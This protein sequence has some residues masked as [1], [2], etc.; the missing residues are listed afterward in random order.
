MN[1]L[2]E[3]LPTFAQNM[4][5]TWAG[6]VRAR[7]RFSR[8]F[9]RMLREWQQT[10]MA[11][12]ESLLIY[13][14]NR[15]DAMVRHAQETVPRYRELKGPSKEPDARRAIQETL[16][17]IPILDKA[18]YRDHFEEFL[19]TNI[20]AGRI[21]RSQTSGTTGTALPLAYTPE[22]IAEEY[23]A[24]WR[25]RARCGIGLRDRHLTFG[26]QVIVPF[27]QS[28]PPFWRENLY[29]RQTL[30]SVHHMTPRNLQLYVDE[31]FKQKAAYIMSYPSSLHLV[32]RAMLETGRTLPAG[33]LKA[34]FTSS[35][36]LL[37]F[38]R[39]AI[40]EAFSTRIW[41]RYGT[42]EFAVS[43]TA[44]SEGLLHVDMEYCVVE[45]EVEEENEDYVRG[46][47]LVTGLSNNATPFLRYRIGDIGTRLKGQCRCGRPG[48][49][50]LD[51]DGRN[52]DYVVTPDGRFIGRL[53]HIFKEQAEI[54]E[55][56]ILQDSP[57]SIEIIF[58]PSAEFNHTS[59][60]ALLR[61]VRK[62]MGDQM[63]IDLKRVHSIPRERNGKFRAVKS[64]VGR[65][66][67]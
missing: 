46:P 33:R 14:R 31:I 4:A 5:C 59:E 35:E 48:D 24:V 52:E 28:G 10:E 67:L 22:A 7:D 40:E 2:Y 23:A 44:C 41:D 1:H 34:I 50:Y 30:F 63:H 58:V 53:D 8:H 12:I 49:V 29:G 66:A 57:E 27:S 9:Y 65:L 61:E 42:S 17:G 62:R 45:V 6:Y 54:L 13:Q 36:S 11:P 47:L 26:G 39:E 3:S 18:T 55:A 19:S 37:A 64:R 43:M 16:A 38:Q 21:R 60:E 56:Q 32:A 25:M 20:P 51:V 15:L